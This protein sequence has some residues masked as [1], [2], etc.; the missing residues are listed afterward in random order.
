M[1]SQEENLKAALVGAQK[2]LALLKDVAGGNLLFFGQFIVQVH[3]NQWSVTPSSEMFLVNKFR[4]PNSNRK[5]CKMSR[6]SLDDITTTAPLVA[7][8][9][10]DDFKCLKRGHFCKTLN[11]MGILSSL[12]TQKK[13][14]NCRKICSRKT[15]CSYPLSSWLP[16]SKKKNR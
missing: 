13:I 16:L 3:A 7:Q 4:V 9:G 6:F 15:H 11:I 2:C 1:S 5:T 10:M 14:I 12:Q 8:K